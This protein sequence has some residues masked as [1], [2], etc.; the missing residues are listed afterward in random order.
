MNAQDD[1][2]RSRHHLL[3]QERLGHPPRVALHVRGHPPQARPDL[4]GRQI[5]RHPADLALVQ[6]VAGQQLQNHARSQLPGGL[7]RLG[8]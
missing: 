6:N 1:F 7:D 2:G 8:R 5:D 3:H 4:V